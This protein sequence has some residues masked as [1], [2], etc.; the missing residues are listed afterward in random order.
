MGV[1]LKT[2]RSLKTR[3]PNKTVRKSALPS[4]PFSAGQFQISIFS[5]HSQEAILYLSVS[6]KFTRLNLV[7]NFLFLLK[8]DFQLLLKQEFF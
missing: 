4:C 5:F 6:K 8:N 2:P 7:K 1:L 3:T